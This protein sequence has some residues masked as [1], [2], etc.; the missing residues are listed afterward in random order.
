MSRHDHCAQ[1]HLGSDGLAK[2]REGVV[3]GVDAPSHGLNEEE[4][5]LSSG[6]YNDT[7]N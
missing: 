7:E 5:I 3:G 4:K 2:I 6:E 1:L